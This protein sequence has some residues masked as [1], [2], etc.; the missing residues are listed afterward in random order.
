[1][2]QAQLAPPSPAGAAASDFGELSRAA[3]ATTDR[4]AVPAQGYRWLVSPRYDLF[5]FVGSCALTFAFYGLYRVAHHFGFFLRGD[6]I[7][8]TYFLFT[9]FFDHPHIFQTFSRTHFDRDEFAR[10]R[11]LYTWGLPGFIAAGFAAT[12]AGYEAHLIVLAAVFGTW[13][14]I[15]QHAGLMKAYKIINRDLDPIDNRL[16]SLTFYTGMFACFF[17][18]YSG[19]R[20]PIVVYNDLRVNFPSLPPQVGRWVWTAFLGL[21]VAYGA[22]LVWRAMEGRPLNVP[23]LLLMAAALSTHYFVFFATMTPFLVAEALETVYH[24]VQYQGWIGY[25]QRK[26]FP[27]VRRVTLKW[28]SLALV[29]GLVVGVIEVLGLMHRGWAMWLFVPFT[30]IVLFHYYVDGLVWRFRDYPKLRALLFR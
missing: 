28:L 16:D 26:R 30:M 27:D 1:M 14:I 25:Y 22:R 4:D 9:A 7:L 21:L 15:R 3:V 10:R 2:T 29:Y 12:A 13:H 23:K 11:R 18:D 19:I 17:N 5:F 8:I 24:D 6:S 20:G